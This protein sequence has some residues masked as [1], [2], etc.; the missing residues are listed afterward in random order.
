MK[1]GMNKFKFLV[2]IF[3]LLST[4]Y[5]KNAYASN[6]QEFIRLSKFKDAL[7]EGDCQRYGGT[8]KGLPDDAFIVLSEAPNYQ[9]LR[10]VVRYRGNIFVFYSYAS[11]GFF[12]KM[13]GVRTMSICKF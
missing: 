5:F 6:M 2:M 11:S 3:L 9:G 4:Y 12:N 1:T 10:N 7:V 8:T 13:L